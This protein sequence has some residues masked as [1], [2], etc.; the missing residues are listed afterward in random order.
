MS[1]II[2][3]GLDGATMP[4]LGGDKDFVSLLFFLWTVPLLD[5]VAFRILQ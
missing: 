4:V 3:V 2:Q 5:S 1:E